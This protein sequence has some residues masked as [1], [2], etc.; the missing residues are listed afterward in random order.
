[1]REGTRSSTEDHTVEKAV[2]HLQGSYG[3]ATVRAA[4][5]RLKGEVPYDLEEGSKPPV[6]DSKRQK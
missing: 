1:M 6:R 2:A 4:D 5:K 3:Q